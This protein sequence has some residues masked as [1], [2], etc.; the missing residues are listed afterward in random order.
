MQNKNSEND[1]DIKTKEVQDIEVHDIIL[2]G[3]ETAY[4]IQ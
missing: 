1:V 3:F 4:T 2:R